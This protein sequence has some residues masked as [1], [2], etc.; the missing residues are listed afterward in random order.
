M[1]YLTKF[2]NW[3]AVVA[4]PVVFI[5]RHHEGGYVW[6]GVVFFQ[7]LIRV[8]ADD[9]G[10]VD[11]DGPALVSLVIRPGKGFH[12]LWDAADEGHVFVREVVPGAGEVVDGVGVGGVFYF[13]CPR[14]FRAEPALGV[15][16][17]AWQV[18][19]GVFGLETFLDQQFR[20]RDGIDGLVYFALFIAKHAGLVF[21]KQFAD[22]GVAGLT[23]D[24]PRADAAAALES[25]KGGFAEQVIKAPQRLDIAVEIDAAFVVNGV[26]PDV[27]ADE[28]VF[29]LCIRLPDIRIC[30]DWRARAVPEAELV[31]RQIA[32]PRGDAS[33]YDF[34]I[35]IAAEPAVVDDLR[36]AHALPSLCF[37]SR[38][39]GLFFVFLLQQLCC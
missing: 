33:L 23:R 7:C 28:R 10:A 20:R 25:E 32:P 3:D 1:V 19:D 16:G 18:L 34:W 39:A 31:V 4:A 24:E 9:A 38:F 13:P 29:L 35:R 36:D 30:V 21:V 5:V 22:D 27:V 15:D 6:E 2:Y 14:V 12:L 37:L 11:D 8:V 17:D 26:K